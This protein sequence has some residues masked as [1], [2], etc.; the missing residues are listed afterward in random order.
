MKTLFCVMS[1]I[2]M[3]TASARVAVAAREYVDDPVAKFLKVREGRE[4]D[5]VKKAHQ[6][7]WA[8]KG[9]DNLEDL[10][11][12][13]MYAPE[14]VLTILMMAYHGSEAAE[15]YILDYA[16]CVDSPAGALAIMGSIFLNH[17][18]VIPRLLYRIGRSGRDAGFFKGV[19][20]TALANLTGNYMEPDQERWQKWWKENKDG[21][22]PDNKADMGLY[23]YEMENGPLTTKWV[24]GDA[25]R[26]DRFMRLLTEFNKE[27]KKFSGKRWPLDKALEAMRNGKFDDARK[28]AQ[29]ALKKYPSEAYA[30]Y[31]AGCTALQ[32]DDVKAARERFDTLVALNSRIGS[33]RL[34]AA[35]C[36]EILSKGKKGVDID[37]LLKLFRNLPPETTHNEW[38]VPTTYIFDKVFVPSQEA[39]ERF[40]KENIN[41]AE[42]LAG[43]IM[44][45]KDADLSSEI[46]DKGIKSNPNSPLLRMLRLQFLMQ[47]G[48]KENSRQIREEI[49]A[50]RLLEGEN[51]LLDCLSIVVGKPDELDKV[52]MTGR[53]TPLT[54]SEMD[55]LAKASTR[56][57]FTLLSGQRVGALLA[58][59]REMGSLTPLAIAAQ[60]R[61]E[62]TLPRV[63]W[64]LSTVAARAEAN[65]ADAVAND[66]MKEAERVYALLETL[67]NRIL[68][69]DKSFS[70]A[71]AALGIL[72]H[73][74]S[75]MAAGYK[76]RGEND[77]AQERWD[78]FNRRAQK[79]GLSPVDLDDFRYIRKIP[80]PK[81]AE[82]LSAAMLSDERT[83][84]RKYPPVYEGDED[85]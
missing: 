75:G 30:L 47:A 25:G 73:A 36:K 50:V 82:A 1:T 76:Q 26:D 78:K 33:A 54:K 14:A 77:K 61:K 27:V 74:E 81:I 49:A 46:L 40:A 42:L 35:Y 5:K 67:A 44:M 59:L 3:L 55:A 62:G 9:I 52:D 69:E 31:I 20:G 83:L 72:R 64:V 80:V 37:I 29:A 79:M 57:R 12:E 7:D 63:G 19:A 43:A 58:T 10:A 56:R 41:K 84:Y 18:K 85:K 71:G 45:L 15:K 53:G 65:I 11:E 32:A 66:N 68:N 22:K 13:E 28:A 23:R 8:V 34:L 6:N 51:G 39:I 4:W 48:I 17:E 24:F 2:L 21:F 38:D 70:N 60:T 16:E